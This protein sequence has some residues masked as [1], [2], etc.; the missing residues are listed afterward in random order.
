MRVKC[1]SIFTLM[2]RIEELSR[3]CGDRS[4]DARE[5][6]LEL[7]GGEGDGATRRVRAD[8]KSFDCIGCGL[9]VREGEMCSDTMTE[10]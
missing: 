5:E 6:R 1:G 7:E 10:S 4:T 8:L 3:G 9:G 2:G